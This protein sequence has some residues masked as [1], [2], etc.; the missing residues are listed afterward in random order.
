MPAFRDLW[1]SVWVQ[2]TLPIV[3]THVESPGNTDLQHTEATTNLAVSHREVCVGSVQVAIL[4]SLMYEST[5]SFHM[6]FQNTG[7][8]QLLIHESESERYT[9]SRQGPRDP[10]QWNMEDVMQ[11]IREADPQL[12]SHAELF[13]K[14]EIDGKA[15]LLL[16]SDVMMKYM[17]LK[18]GPALKLSHHIDKLKQGKF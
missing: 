5:G 18:L 15:L 3:R 6:I 8:L 2:E 11:F 10:S 1:S 14:H 17:G 13:R 16:R 9:S 7:L 12:G 4:L